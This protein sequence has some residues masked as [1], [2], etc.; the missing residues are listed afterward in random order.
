VRQASRG[1][2]RG[3]GSDASVPPGTAEV[4][5]TSISSLWSTGDCSATSTRSPA[6]RQERTLSP[7]T[8]RSEPTSTAR[9]ATASS[10]PLRSSHTRW[11]RPRTSA[12]PTVS[13]TPAWAMARVPRARSGGGA[14][15]TSRCSAPVRNR[16]STATTG[17]SP[18]CLRRVRSASSTSIDP[19]TEG[20]SRRGIA[21]VRGSPGRNACSSISTRSSTQPAIT[22]PSDSAAKIAGR[23]FQVT[24][25]RCAPGPKS[26]PCIHPGSSVSTTQRACTSSPSSTVRIRT[27]RSAIFGPGARSGSGTT[28]KA[29]A[30]Q[31]SPCNSTDPA[32][33][34]EC[35]TATRIR[36]VRYGGIVGAT[37]RGFRPLHPSVVPTEAT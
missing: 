29:S 37:S 9:N 35:S 6:R 33:A 2:I 17:R 24:I 32:S 25:S 20:S 11:A 14:R 18:F 12:S 13:P 36:A 7:T 27:D 34:G 3:R 21:R 5:R 28:G 19:R 22:V 1:S 16:P 31:V 4:Q 23:P 30:F 10:C 8:S 26:T 15:A